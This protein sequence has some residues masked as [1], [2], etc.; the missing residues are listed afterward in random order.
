MLVGVGVAVVLLLASGGS[1]ALA[2]FTG[3]DEMRIHALS[4]ERR[5]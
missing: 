5:S 3:L 4:R 1:E 2:A